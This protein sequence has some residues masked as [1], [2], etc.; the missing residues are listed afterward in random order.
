[1][2][3]LTLPIC[4]LLLS[5][6]TACSGT[7]NQFIDVSVVNSASVDL[8]DTYV[9]LSGIRCGWGVVVRNSKKVFSGAKPR[10]LAT[11]QLH[12]VQQGK[13]RIERFDLRSM[14]R[15]GQSGELTFTVYDDRVEVSFAERK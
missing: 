14:Y 5:A 2:K 10:D 15:I 13:T 7:R 9:D 8:T 12:L 1:M 11:A 4:L 6:M 3:N